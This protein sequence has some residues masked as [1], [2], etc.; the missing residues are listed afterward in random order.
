[1]TVAQR[2]RVADTHTCTIHA[3]YDSLAALESLIAV[4]RGIAA[5]DPEHVQ[6]SEDIAHAEREIEARRARIARLEGLMGKDS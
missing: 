3:P 1:V 4:E 5:R 6:A 2:D